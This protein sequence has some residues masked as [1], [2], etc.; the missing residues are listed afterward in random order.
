M[1]TSWAGAGQEGPVRRGLQP[2]QACER[3]ARDQEV[4]LEKS[5][6]L[7]VGPTGCGKT[8]LA[9]TLAKVLDVPFSIADATALTEAGYVGEDVENILLHL[10]QSADF[11]VQRAERGIIYIDEIDKIARKATTPRSR[12]T[13]RE[14]GSSRRC[15][16]SSRGRWASVPPQG[17]RKHP[18]QDFIQI[19]TSRILFICGGA[20]EGWRRSSTGAPA[21]AGSRWA[22]G[23]SIGPSR[24]WA[25]CSADHARRP[26]EVRA[27]PG[28]R[29]APADGGRPGAAG[30]RSHGAHSH[31][32]QERHRAPVPALL[33]H[34]RR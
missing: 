2:L 21:V 27:D 33:R 14:K 17:G 7:F 31:G 9:R 28:V 19:D 6:I 16:R 34:G 32:A 15:S 13:S 11:D 30:P 25:T 3:E 20:F 26:P 8:L 4:E 24:T 1:S 23:R 18:H 5:N 10:I 22:T 29:R 12:G